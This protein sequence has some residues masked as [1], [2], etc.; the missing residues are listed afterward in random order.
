MLL[1]NVTTKAAIPPIIVIPQTTLKAVSLGNSKERFRWDQTISFSSNFP[2]SP[3]DL[4]HI[5]SIFKVEL[6]E[7]LLINRDQT[8]LEK[9]E[10]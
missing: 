4:A 10:H 5:S 3:S 7:S 9:T 1:I 2:P 6:N 8:P